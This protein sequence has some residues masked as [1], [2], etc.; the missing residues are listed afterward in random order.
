MRDLEQRLTQLTGPGATETEGQPANVREGTRNL[1]LPNRVPEMENQERPNPA[2]AANPNYGNQ[3]AEGQH[4]QNHL[5]QA[6]GQE[7]RNRTHPDKNAQNIRGRGEPG[8]YRRKYSSPFTGRILNAAFPEDFDSA[9]LPKYYGSQDPQVPGLQENVH[10]HLIVA[11]LDG[12]SRL[13]KSVYKDPVRKLEEFRTRSKKYLELEQMEISNA[14]SEEGKRVIPRRRSPAPKGK[15]RV[16][17]KK[18]D[19]RARVPDMRDQ[20][21]RYDKYTQLN[22]SRS[23]IWREVAMTEIKKVDRPRPIFDRGGLDKSKYCVFHDGPGHTTDQCWDLRD[24]EKK[25]VRDGRL[26]QYVIKTQGS[27]N[28]K[29]KSRNR[30]RSKSPVPEKKNKDERDRKDDPNFDEFPEAEFDCNVIS[31]AL[32]R[33]GDTI[34]ARRKYLKEFLSIRDRPKFMEDPNKPDPHLLYFTKEDMHG[35]LPGHVDGLVIGGTLVNCRVKKIFVDAGSSADIILLDAFKKMNLDEEDL[36]PCK[37]TLI[38]FNGEHTPP[39][40]YID[41]RLTQG[42][43]EAFKS[44]RVRFIVADFPS[45]YN[46]ILGRPTI[47][48]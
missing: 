46:I 11:G 40:G 16:D 30:K 33:G 35:V 47:H 25:F 27:K 32:G 19:P 14:Q 39:K 26:R 22:A 21:G 23:Q 37:T 28:N 1:I 48:Q 9:R 17:N 42:T 5:A 10:V 8:G 44:E 41:L 45:E 12:A 43:K 2:N 31:G 15:E 36:E 3:A 34:S 6:N 29:R 18:K 7:D 24:A 20:V 4:A 13:A 38:A